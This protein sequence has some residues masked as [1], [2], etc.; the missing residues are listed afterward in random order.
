MVQVSRNVP[1]SGR[2]LAEYGADVL[3]ITSPTYPYTFAQHLG[4]DIGKRCAYLDLRDADDLAQMHALASTADV[5]ITTYRGSV[6]RRFGLEAQALA[7]RSKRGIVCMTANAY[8]HAGPW[9]DRPGFDQNGQVAS[10]FAAKEGEPVSP[11][12]RP[13]SIS[14]IS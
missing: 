4:V 14:L 12:S 10:G 5:F 9:A 11:A 8:G 13:S 3:H 6:N 1:L 7:A 2:T